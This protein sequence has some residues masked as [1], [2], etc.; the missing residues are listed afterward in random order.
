MLLLQKLKCLKREGEQVECEDKLLRQLL[1]RAL[2]NATTQSV[3]SPRYVQRLL[4]AQHA[5][6]IG[7]ALSVKQ[8]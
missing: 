6:Y 5:Q 4:E 3:T 1:G 8:R 2:D 7:L